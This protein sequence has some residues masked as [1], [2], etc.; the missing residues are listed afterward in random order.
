MCEPNCPQ[1]NHDTF[2]P[3]ADGAAA[4][5]EQLRFEAFQMP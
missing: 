2:E 4:R 1:I 3:W 5:G